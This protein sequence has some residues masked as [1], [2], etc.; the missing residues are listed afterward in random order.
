MRVQLLF[1]LLLLAIIYE[2]QCEETTAETS[3]TNGDRSKDSNENKPS[4]SDDDDDDTDLKPS[5]KKS[6]RRRKSPD[7]IGHMNI[8]LRGSSKRGKKEKPK[9]FRFPVARYDRRRYRSFG[10]LIN[11]LPWL[12][13]FVE[14]R[15]KQ[16]IIYSPTGGVYILPPVINFYGKVYSIGEL[17]ASGY[18]SLVSTGASPP[19]AV[20]VS[21][22]VQTGAVVGS[23]IPTVNPATGGFDTGVQTNFGS[24]AA[25]KYSNSY[26]GMY[27]Y[28]Q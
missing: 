3:V 23:G 22:L 19:P 15:T 20:D 28:Q 5:E 6:K 18:A 27:G 12:P 11:F 4:K 25:P 9:R 7:Y 21:P 24:F 10:S 13:I 2:Y 17:I 8:Y 1:I 16:T 26:R 14:R